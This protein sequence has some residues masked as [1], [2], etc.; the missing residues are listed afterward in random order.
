MISSKL[1]KQQD[2]E[3]I[4]LI[5]DI[6]NKKNKVKV[7]KRISIIKEIEG[8]NKKTPIKKTKEKPLFRQNNF[9][10]LN[11]IKKILEQESFYFST[12]FDYD[13]YK[14]NNENIVRFS[15]FYMGLNTK[16]EE[17]TYYDSPVL[18]SHKV[19]DI[20]NKFKFAQLKG[21]FLGDYFIPENVNSDDFEKFYYF[22]KLNPFLMILKYALNPL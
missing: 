3:L 2:S 14:I 15:Q 8:N 7:I 1:K 5:Q 13:N 20:M 19:D 18:D 6:E 21:L 9:D 22:K 12:K 10:Y 16:S 4:S 11:L 17:I